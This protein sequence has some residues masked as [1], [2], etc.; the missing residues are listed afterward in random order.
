MIPLLLSQASLQT[1]S[2]PTAPRLSLSLSAD[3][4]S[5]R[6]KEIPKF[7][8][9]FRNESQGSVTLVKCL[10]GS[11]ERMR[12]PHCVVQYFDGERW[13]ADPVGRCGNTNNLQ[14]SDFQ[15]LKP[16]EKWNPVGEWF[17]WARIASAFQKA[18]IVKV[19]FVYEANTSD[20][21]RWLGRMGEV[22]EQ[23]QAEL[24]S[25]LDKVPKGQWESNV[26]LI[27]VD[28]AP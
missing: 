22:P 14:A 15:S 13:T 2:Q 21:S 11:Q 9:Q 25:G 12:Y 7:S 16:G 23:T 5:V 8:V 18:G 26:V 24:R 3:R 10:D 4:A 19:R 6:V 20:L 17:D 27:R 1:S 28:N